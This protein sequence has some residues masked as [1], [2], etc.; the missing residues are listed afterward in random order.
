MDEL[1]LLAEDAGDDLILVDHS[2]AAD[3]GA[4]PEVFAGG[5]GPFSYAPRKKEKG[6]SPRRR[7][8]LRALALARE[9]QWIERHRQAQ[10]AAVRDRNLL[11]A[12]AALQ[13]KRDREARINRERLKNLKK[14]REARH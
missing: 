11:K 14:A 5:G 3:Q 13:E 12:Q 6:I 1:F 9:V 2:V 4:I 7:G 8:N 10:I